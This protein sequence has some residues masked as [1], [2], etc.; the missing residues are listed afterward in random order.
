MDA[1][2]RSQDSFV[3][4]IT[5]QF[6]INENSGIS[7]KKINQFVSGEG[8]GDNTNKIIITKNR[9]DE[10]PIEITVAENTYDGNLDQSELT[11]TDFVISELLPDVINHLTLQRTTGREPISSPAL[12]RIKGR[13]VTEFVKEVVGSQPFYIFT[14][15]IK[16]ISATSTDADLE[17]WDKHFNLLRPVNKYISEYQAKAI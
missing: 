15:L 2:R 16:Q 12:S 11:S 10:F 9:Q 6:T 13:K 5:E 8:N 17:D 1:A 7:S 4:K 14:H 3:K